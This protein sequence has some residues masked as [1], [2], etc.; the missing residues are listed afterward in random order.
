MNSVQSRTNFWSFVRSKS[1]VKCLPNILKGMGNEVT[2]AIEKSQLFN[3]YFYSVFNDSVVGRAPNI[4]RKINDILGNCII[5]ISRVR[6][7]LSTLDSSK[8]T[9]S[10]QLL[11]KFFIEC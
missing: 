4:D 10:D 2:S 9:G 7:A 8:A 11:A 1:K 5:E 6:L 3:E